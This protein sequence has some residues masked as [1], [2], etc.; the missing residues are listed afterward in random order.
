VSLAGLSLRDLEYLVAVA[1]LRHFGHAA[2]RCGVS[3]PAL[4][5]Q[6]RKLESLLGVAV[7][8]RAPK[9]V[10]I[11]EPGRRIVD[12]ARRV[13]LEASH[14]FTVGVAMRVL[15]YE[16]F[17]AALP[18]GHR[19]CK[20]RPLLLEALDGE[21]LLLLEEGN[22]LRDQLVALCRHAGHAR[23]YAAS[24]E[25]LR[26]MVAT[27]SGYSVVPALAAR[28]AETFAGLVE[29]R[30]IEGC[31]AGRTIALVWRS[32]DPRTAHYGRIGEIVVESLSEG[33]WVVPALAA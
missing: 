5:A 15:F 23:R 3:Q 32:S 25:T 8:E 27:D 26:R 18:A 21:G 11:T 33:T 28:N 19:L 20:M 9:H 1:E 4:S 16:P 31:K 24:L 6:I 13:V 2:R 12:Q 30:P 14:L 29:Y 22:C 17:V 10:I 7:F